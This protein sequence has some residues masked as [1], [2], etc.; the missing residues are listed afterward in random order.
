MH[1]DPRPA[2]DVREDRRDRGPDP[3]EGRGRVLLVGVQEGAGALGLGEAAAHEHLCQRTAHAE[4]AL[5]ARG[6]RLEA[7]RYL[8]LANLIH[9]PRLRAGSDTQLPARRRRLGSGGRRELSLRRR[10]SSLRPCV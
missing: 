8:E 2:A 6:L 9:R 3:G 7:G 10:G 4:L 1:G 5:Q